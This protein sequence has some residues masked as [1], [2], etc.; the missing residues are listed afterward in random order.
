VPSAARRPGE[1]FSY[2]RYVF[3]NMVSP[4]NG[5]ITRA[6]RIV[7]DGGN[8]ACVVSECHVWVTGLGS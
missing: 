2:A 3:E 1:R 4:P 8:A 5:G 7:Y 6:S